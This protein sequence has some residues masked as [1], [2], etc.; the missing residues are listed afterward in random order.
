MLR[1]TRLKSVLKYSG[2]KVT[3]LRNFGTF[4]YKIQFKKE[5]QLKRRE[6]RLGGEQEQR[7]T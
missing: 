4:A 5:K 2:S 3:E 7:C 6:L 1:V